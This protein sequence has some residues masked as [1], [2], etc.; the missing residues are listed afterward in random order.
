MARLILESRTPAAQVRVED[1]VHLYERR[2][3]W[4]QGQ[5]VSQELHVSCNFHHTAPGASRK[6]LIR[7][8]GRRRVAG[9]RGRAP[10]SK[11]T[12]MGGLVRSLGSPVG[13]SATNHLPS[14]S[15]PESCRW[16]VVCG[17]ESAA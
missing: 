15:V 10:V 11:P 3:A 9:Q 6:S 13:T 5:Q 12:T 16:P 14:P 2:G 17:V 7:A 4:R 1:D 8:L